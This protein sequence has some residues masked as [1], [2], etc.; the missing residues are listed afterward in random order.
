MSMSKTGKVIVIYINSQNKSLYLIALEVLNTFLFTYEET[1]LKSYAGTNF[2]NCMIFK[3]P[4][5]VDV[6]ESIENL[7]LILIYYCNK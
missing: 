6:K 4:Q 3:H 1:N 5:K 7:V 2:D